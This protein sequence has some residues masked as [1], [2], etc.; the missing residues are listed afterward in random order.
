LKTSLILVIIAKFI[1]FIGDSI[2]ENGNNNPLCLPGVHSLEGQT[3][4]SYFC[5]PRATG[6]Y[7]NIRQTVPGKPV[8][9]AEIAVYSES[10]R[11]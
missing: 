7:V 1:S 9:I 3:T 4:G 10:S 8:A 2:E 5:E 6:K 11:M